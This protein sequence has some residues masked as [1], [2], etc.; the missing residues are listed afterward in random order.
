MIRARMNVASIP[1]LLFQ[2][3]LAHG[4]ESIVV[5]HNDS[6]ATESTEKNSIVPDNNSEIEAAEIL[7]RRVN[8]AEHFRVVSSF[9]CRNKANNF[10][11]AV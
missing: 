11:K 9:M 6:P 1:C 7:H 8:E 3:A 10:R 2:D 4:S 5:A